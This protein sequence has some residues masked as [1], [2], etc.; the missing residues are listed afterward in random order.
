MLL[1]IGPCRLDPFEGSSYNIIKIKFNRELYKDTVNLTVYRGLNVKSIDQMLNYY[2]C[3]A[4]GLPHT[5]DQILW[6]ELILLVLYV[7]MDI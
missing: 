4:H 3:T 7:N 6:S 5:H 2:Y 1:K